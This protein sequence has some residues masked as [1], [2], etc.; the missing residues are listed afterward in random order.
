MSQTSQYKNYDFC[1]GLQLVIARYLNERSCLLP[2][3]KQVFVAF[4]RLKM[5][6][7][8]RYTSLT[9]RA[10]GSVPAHLTVPYIEEMRYVIG[11]IWL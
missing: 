11:W 5:R 2:I 6:R 10:E 3:S 7:E 1:F 4:Q 9:I 8:I